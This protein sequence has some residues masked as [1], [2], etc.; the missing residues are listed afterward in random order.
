MTQLLL[1]ILLYSE[2]LSTKSSQPDSEVNN[3]LRLFGT[4]NCTILPAP[5][6]IK[7]VS[8]IAEEMIEKMS[9]TTIEAVF[10]DNN[11]GGDADQSRGPADVDEN[12]SVKD[13]PRLLALE[14]Y[15]PAT[16]NPKAL[17]MS[18]L[19]VNELNI[20]KIYKFV[21][22]FDI[23]KLNQDSALS[24]MNLS[25]VDSTLARLP[26]QLK[27]LMLGSTENN[28]DKVIQH[29]NTPSLSV[30]NTYRMARFIFD[31]LLIKEVQ[32]G[33]VSE[34]SG[35]LMWNTLTTAKLTKYE[36]HNYLLCRLV[37]YDNYML[38]Y[39]Q[40]KPEGLDL[41]VFD[42]HFLLELNSAATSTNTSTDLIEK[43]IKSAR[44]INDS[45]KPEETYTSDFSVPKEDIL[46]SGFSPSDLPIDTA[47]TAES[48]V[49]P[50][51]G[52][53]DVQSSQTDQSSDNSSQGMPG[54]NL[55]GGAL[56]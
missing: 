28:S 38:G 21:R 41:P 15:L 8:E 34:S 12:K 14:A 47:F 3:L 54:S 23:T 7:K 55:D 19:G 56:Y 51:S 16:T 29:W 50:D 2:G 11:G 25:A 42:Q 5:I 9:M 45:Q 35:N 36:N 24:L 48:Q 40:K 10:G 13:V 20:G 22:E 44:S 4:K 1:N 18:L 49:Q 37:P 33:K 39:A 52:G 26:N 6:G 53:V 27:S 43:M 31:Y 46:A 30:A 32:F 17:L